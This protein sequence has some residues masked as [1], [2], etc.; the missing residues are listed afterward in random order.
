MTW[1]RALAAVLWTVAL[2]GFAV[3]IGFITLFGD[4]PEHVIYGWSGG[5]ACSDQKR[6]VANCI[7]FGFPL[8]WLV[9]TIGIFRFRRR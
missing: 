6:L 9:G 1:R 5:T 3:C 8:L 4:C 2:A 7:L